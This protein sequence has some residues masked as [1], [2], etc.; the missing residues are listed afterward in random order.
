[1]AHCGARCVSRFGAG[2]LV[3]PIETLEPAEPIEPIERIKSLEP[4]EQTN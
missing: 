2:A 3:A 1:M 4:S